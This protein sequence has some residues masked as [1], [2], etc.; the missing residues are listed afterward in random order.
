MSEV[1]LNHNNLFKLLSKNIS[2]FTKKPSACSMRFVTAHLCYQMDSEFVTLDGVEESSIF[3]G[4]LN[5]L[6]TFK[7]VRNVLLL[8]A[9]V[10][11]SKTQSK[12]FER[13]RLAPK[14]QLSFIK[15]TEVNLHCKTIDNQRK[16]T[17]YYANYVARTYYVILLRRRFV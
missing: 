1:C 12:N 5:N 16:D 11:I 9:T 8:T 4:I 14:N 15:N 7:E 2:I 6:E 13:T 10:T 17:N 3:E